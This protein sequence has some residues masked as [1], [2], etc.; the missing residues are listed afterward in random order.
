MISLMKPW[1]TTGSRGKVPP[2]SWGSHRAWGRGRGGVF[3]RWSG[4]LAWELPIRGRGTYQLLST[5]EGRGTTECG[6]SQLGY[7]GGWGR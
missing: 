4:W 3:G 6:E 5:T 7:Q 2:M 1:L